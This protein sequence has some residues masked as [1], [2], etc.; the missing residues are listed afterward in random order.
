M[1]RVVHMPR[2]SREVL[3]SRL[4]L[5]VKLSKRK[6]RLGQSWYH[7]A[8][9]SQANPNEYKEVLTK[10]GYRFTVKLCLIISPK[11]S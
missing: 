2:K 3:K 10:W 4:W 9:A 11:L 8:E 6:G 1:P 5:H 7:L